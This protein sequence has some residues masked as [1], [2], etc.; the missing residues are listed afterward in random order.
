M[1]NKKGKI[2]VQSKSYI[3][4]VRGVNAHVKKN[5]LEKQKEMWKNVGVNIATQKKKLNQQ[6]AC[7]ITSVT[8]LYEKF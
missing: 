3:I 2:T 4:L 8:C 7:L 5:T 1:D 6:D